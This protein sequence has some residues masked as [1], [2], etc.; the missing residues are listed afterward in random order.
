V[1]FTFL[2]AGGQILPIVLLAVG[3]T[4]G[5]RDWPA[6]AP[7][8]AVVA[9]GLVWLPRFL[10]AARFRQSVTSAISHPLGVAVFLAI[11]WTALTRKMLGLH[12]SW[13]GRSLVP[14]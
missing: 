11:Q 6:W 5:W 1:P 12:T 8:V 7:A 4:T 10:E 13:R 3:L 9:A 14:Q 2:L